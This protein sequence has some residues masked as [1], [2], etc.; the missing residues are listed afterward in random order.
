MY[1]KLLKQK[2]AIEKLATLISSRVPAAQSEYDRGDEQPLL[3][4]TSQLRILSDMEE[5]N[6]DMIYVEVG[7]SETEWLQHTQPPLDLG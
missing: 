6:R 1:E 7:M 4:L 2:R 5:T 3:W